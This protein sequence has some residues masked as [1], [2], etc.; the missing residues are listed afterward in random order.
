[1]RKTTRTWFDKLFKIKASYEIK[2][3]GSKWNVINHNGHYLLVKEYKH[4]GYVYTWYGHISF[5]SDF[6][7][8]EEAKKALMK[9]I[10][11]HAFKLKHQL[12]EAEIEKTRKS[13]PVPPWN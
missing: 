2:P 10:W 9:A 13:I 5:S 1:M 8:I 12:R 11:Y 4:L 7:S 6:E 3:C